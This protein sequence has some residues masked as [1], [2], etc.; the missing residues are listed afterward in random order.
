ML[1]LVGEACSWFIDGPHVTATWILLPVVRRD[2]DRLEAHLLPLNEQVG[3]V[4]L[5]HV[6]TQHPSVP[7]LEIFKCVKRGHLL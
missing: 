1:V 7:G 6:V 5:P 2:P 4:G 3:Q